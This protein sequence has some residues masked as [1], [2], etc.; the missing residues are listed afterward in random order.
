MT[1]TVLLALA[2]ALVPACL[3]AVD[4]Q[5]LINQSTVMAA[6]GFPYKITLPGSYKLTGNLTMTTTVSGNFNGTDVAIEIDSGQVILDLNGFT[7]FIANNFAF[8]GHAYYAISGFGYGVTI[9]NGNIVISSASVLTD[10]SKACGICLLPARNTQIEGIT[11]VADPNS[12]AEATSLNVNVGSIVRGVST[13]VPSN[14]S[15]PSVLIGT[16]GLGALGPSCV[17]V[18]AI[19]P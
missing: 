15:C 14:I 2:I 6:G 10:V 1:K 11:I 16:F 18:G 4:G 3:F 7:I 17:T 9:R 5:V 13:N 19:A 8:P 12:A